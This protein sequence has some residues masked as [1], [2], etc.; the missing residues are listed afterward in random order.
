MPNLSGV[1]I[2]HGK[3]KTILNISEKIL[4]AH[5]LLPKM[6]VSVDFISENTRKQRSELLRWPERAEW[7]AKFMEYPWQVSMVTPISHSYSAISLHT[8][9]R[10]TAVLRAWGKCRDSAVSAK[11]TFNISSEIQILLHGIPGIQ[12]DVHWTVQVY[13]WYG[14]S[15]WSYI[16]RWNLKT[17]QKDVFQFTFKGLKLAGAGSIS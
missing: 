15:K 2:Y 4:L 11:F 16:R 1:P 3:H 7:C 14:C 10:S 6:S 12:N 17:I 9:R 13:G 8:A 5:G